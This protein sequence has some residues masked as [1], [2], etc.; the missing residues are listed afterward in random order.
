MCCILKKM[1]RH[2]NSDYYCYRRFINLWVDL[3]SD[4]IV[5]LKVVGH[6][7][8][9]IWKLVGMSVKAVYN[10]MKRYKKSTLP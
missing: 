6:N 7:N 10:F 2:C 3:K 1:C 5:A 4:H 9:K 8:Y